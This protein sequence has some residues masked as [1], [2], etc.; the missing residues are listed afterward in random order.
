MA[1]PAFKVTDDPTVAARLAAEGT[2][3][4]LVGADAA[5]LG[6]VLA[7][8]PDRDGREHLLAVM[9]GGPGDPAVAAAAAEMAAEL[10]G[11]GRGR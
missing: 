5:A 10:G 7:T 11:P 4:V 2:P 9:V 6:A 3:V 8:A 1:T